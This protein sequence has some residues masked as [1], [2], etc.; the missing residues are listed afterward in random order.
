MMV[1]SSNSTNIGQKLIDLLNLFEISV[2][3]NEIK[4]I[5]ILNISDDSRQVSTGTL[6][7]AREGT[8]IH[9]EQFISDAIK[10]GA[11]AILRQSSTN[12][13]ELSKGEINWIST[14]INK[15][16]PEIEFRFSNRDI[17]KLATVFYK[18]PSRNIQVTGITGTNGKTSC[19]YILANLI[20]LKQ[21][22]GF[23]GTIGVGEIN[24]LVETNNTTL[25]VVENQK[26]FSEMYGKG[27]KQVVM[28]V[29]SHALTQQRIEGVN[30][31]C[32]VFTNLTH[33]HLDYH[34]TFENYGQAKLGL[35]RLNSLESAVIN[36]DDI[37]SEKILEIISSDVK[38]ITYG[39]DNRNADVFAEIIE[40]KLNSTLINI[41]TKNE[42]I[43]VKVPLLGKFNISNLLAVCGVLLSQGES[44]KELSKIITGVKV[45][46]GRMQCLGGTNKLPLVVVDYAH[47]PDALQNVLETLR[48]HCT[49]KL[50]CVFGCGGDRDKDKRSVMGHIVSTFADYVVITNDNPRMEQ[51]MVIANEIASGIKNK[52]IASIILDRKEAIQS[53]IKKATRSDVI[54]IAGKGHESYQ[55]ID[56]IKYYFDD[57]KISL[58]TL[59]IEGIT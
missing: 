33:D 16:I 19:A 1:S 20:N 14:A 54:L 7:I 37:F 39:I 23:I 56:T 35:F 47:T 2:D 12:Q 3:F 57:V 31:K 53:T 36:V 44:L 27:I 41:K 18:D 34:Q 15:S 40:F 6:F 10:N 46:K 4:N 29:S 28:E 30:I 11:A 13:S 17:S 42:S 51:P 21:Q 26:I 9:G 43:K 49:G 58:E 48:L 8:A 22:C 25:G 50:W 45:V 32:A 55:I 59:N 24:S 52:N 5:E 38:V